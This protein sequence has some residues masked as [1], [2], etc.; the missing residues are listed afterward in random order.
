M[1]ARAWAVFFRRF[2]ASVFFAL[3]RFLGRAAIIYAANT[4]N[5]T[6]AES[7]SRADTLRRE[8]ACRQEN[9]EKKPQPMAT[10][11]KHMRGVW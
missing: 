5:L 7:S 10:R 1:M 11:N 4:I 6:W 9:G 3:F 8:G 2:G